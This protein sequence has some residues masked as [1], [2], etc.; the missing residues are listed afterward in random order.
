MWCRNHGRGCV[1][2]V[3][4]GEPG[5]TSNFFLSIAPNSIHQCLT[6]SDVSWQRLSHTSLAGRS[7]APRNFTTPC[8]CGR[9]RWSKHQQLMTTFETCNLGDAK[10]F[11]VVVV[12]V[13]GCV[14]LWWPEPPICV[15]GWSLFG[16]PCLFTLSSFLGRV[17][18]RLHLCCT[19]P[20]LW[21]L[22]CS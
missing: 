3:R 4:D 17:A 2:R 14:Y 5:C 12:V 8:R 1:T 18:T 7:R 21:A 15:A 10:L 20:T 22:R 16:A 6:P 13:G 19:L 9:R 11:V